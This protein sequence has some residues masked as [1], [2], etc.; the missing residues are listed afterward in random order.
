MHINH[1]G[2][3][4][5]VTRTPVFYTIVWLLNVQYFVVQ[6]IVAGRWK[7]PFSLL[8]NTIS[9]LGNTVCGPYRDG[10]VCSPLHRWMNLS[11][12]GLGLGMMLGAAIIYHRYNRQI[13]TIL[14]G[15]IC[16]VLAGIGTIMVGL[17]PENTIGAVHIWGASLP[18]FF[19]NVALLLFGQAVPMARALRIYTVL[20]GILALAALVLFLTHTYLGLGIGGTER[21]VAYPQTIWLLVFIPHALYHMPR[22]KG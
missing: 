15:I 19:G 22:P 21:I 11:F 18:F 3:P 16:M 8:H 20:S 5:A 17:F 4:R 10:A 12:V 2:A 1:A 13:S 9:D 14:A 7:Q 6:A